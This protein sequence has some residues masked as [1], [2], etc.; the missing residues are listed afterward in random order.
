MWASAMICGTKRSTA[1]RASGATT[2]TSI[3]PTLF[4]AAT[5]AS[6]AR[7]RSAIIGWGWSASGAANENV[8]PRRRRSGWTPGR[9][10]AGS[11]T[12]GP[13]MAI[14]PRRS[15][16][17]ERARRPGVSND[18]ASG[19]L[20]CREIRPMVVFNPRTPQNAA[21]IRIDPPVS[22]PIANGTMPAATAAAD[23][24]LDPPGTRAWSWGFRVD[25][26]SRCWVVIPHPNSCERVRPI[27]TAPAARRRATTVASTSARRP[28]GTSDP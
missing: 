5:A 28:S 14:R 9:T 4:S 15:M 10:D 3:P 26:R 11:A 1:R 23:P 2:S 27:T 13:A 16:S 6:S 7:R 17:T 24:P 22:V 25:P 12:S 8:S 18:G 19:T 21:G 20:P